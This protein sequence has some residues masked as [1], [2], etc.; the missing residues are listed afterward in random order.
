MAEDPDEREPDYRFTLANE[1]TFLAWMRT[2]MALLAGGLAARE[3]VGPFEV[4][5]ARTALAVAAVTLSLVLALGSLVRWRR[6]QRAMRRSE[7]LPHPLAAPVLAIGVATVAGAV[8]LL[9]LL[10]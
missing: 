2:S 6:V 7:P 3:L 1:R 5:G 4:R 10:A 9:V 8:A